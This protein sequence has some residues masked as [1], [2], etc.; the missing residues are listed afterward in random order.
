M[1]RVL[2]MGW[3][4]AALGLSCSSGCDRARS[5]EA[6]LTADFGG[7]KAKLAP[8]DPEL[9][10]DLRRVA[11]SCE[12][13]EGPT[14]HLR[15]PKHGDRALAHEFLKGDRDRVAALPTFASLLE[16][17]DKLLQG[18]ALR[19]LSMGFSPKLGDDLGIG[20]I[21]PALADAFLAAFD[22]L[23]AEQAHSIAAVTVHTALLAHGELDTLY[24]ALAKREQLA[25]DAYRRLMIHG[26]MRAFPKVKQ[27]AEGASTSLAVAALEA[28]RNMANWTSAEQDVLCPWALG[29]LRQ[30]DERRAARAAQ[31]LV[32][33]RG[34]HVD[35]IL[36]L[37]QE[38]DGQGRLTRSRLT[39]FREICQGQGSEAQ[40]EENLG[41][42][43]ALLTSEKN[44]ADLRTMAFSAIMYQVA[45]P[46]APDQL[47]DQG[48]RVQ[49]LRRLAARFSKDEDPWV[50][51]L[52][53]RTLRGLESRQVAKK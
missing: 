14:G 48:P 28:P 6:P 15:C 40:C 8:S 36:A 31:L 49:L 1:R 43:E 39:A 7:S 35:G 47:D 10:D 33:C 53:A 12:L 13:E 19:V 51:K 17:R 9:L 32:N 4:T 2:A 27:L 11:A 22:K 38:L 50:A 25:P 26:R 21:P 5:Q 34:D 41:F 3:L 23:P 16:E 46:Q 24:A 29:F 42:L 37:G 18:V 20:A 44:Q 52:A 30:S 45:D